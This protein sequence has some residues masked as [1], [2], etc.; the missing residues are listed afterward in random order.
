MEVRLVV[1]PAYLQPYFRPKV[2][3]DGIAAI[4][5]D[6]DVMGK[7]LIQAAFPELYASLTV[8]DVFP[9]ADAI[10]TVAV[11]FPIADAI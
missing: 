6:H 1:L 8:A 2:G 4:G 7:T 11:V 9:I 10:L 3:A 5:R